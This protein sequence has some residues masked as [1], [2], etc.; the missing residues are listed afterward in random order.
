MKCIKPLL[1]ALTATCAITVAPLRPVQ[2]QTPPALTLD[3]LTFHTLPSFPR[4][5]GFTATPATIRALGY[6]PSR[7]WLA[8][9]QAGNALWLGDFQN[10]FNLQSFTLRQIGDIT[11]LSLDGRTL[12][13]LELLGWQT[14]EDLARAVPGLQNTRLANLPAVSTLL[15]SLGR[16]VDPRTTLRQI[17]ADRTLAA[18]PLGRV[19]L[20]SFGL[21]ALPGLND[22]PLANFRDWQR[23]SVAGVPGLVDVP[24]DR[25]PTPLSLQ[26]AIPTYVDIAFSNV[27]GGLTRTVSGS[28]QEGFNV[29]CA[30]NC[31]HLELG[32]PFEG[33]QWISGL[34]QQVRGG[35]GVL[36]RLNGGLEPT[37]R[38]PFG[39]GFKVVVLETDEAT[40]TAN[41]GLYFRFCVK[42]TFVDLGCSP[43]FIG[44]VPW[45]PVQEEGVT[46]L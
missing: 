18:L 36:G 7:Q 24:F 26:A 45:L 42:R 1:T 28:Y 44:P 30:A 11:G 46:V 27:E 13:D 3:R 33:Q 2:A 15:A 16:R 10:S 34:S 41:L 12:A 32:L 29:P 5:G 14:L 6:N 19:D 9:K 20:R 31:A 21:I 17:I 35:Y 39:P 4:A 8:G 22:T 43:Y 40:G 23:S 25:F 38:H 37:G